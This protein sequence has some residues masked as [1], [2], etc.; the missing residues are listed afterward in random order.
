MEKSTFTLQVQEFAKT[1]T[2]EEKIKLIAM[3]CDTLPERFQ[4][5]I[6]Q[7]L[8]WQ[9]EFTSNEQTYGRPDLDTRLEQALSFL[10]SLPDQS[11]TIEYNRYLDNDWMDEDDEFYSDFYIEDMDFFLD[12]IE[13]VLSL[14]LECEQEKE[15]AKGAQLCAKLATAQTRLIQERNGREMDSYLTPVVDLISGDIL[16]PET[17]LSTAAW[18]GIH[19]CL[20]GEKNEE[21]YANLFDIMNGFETAGFTLKKLEDYLGY[22]LSD[23]FVVNLSRQYAKKSESSAG[24]FLKLAAQYVQDPDARKEILLQAARLHPEILLQYLEAGKDS[25]SQKLETALA[26]LNVMDPL[27]VQ[28]SDTALYCEELIAKTE[29]HKDKLPFVL[30]QIYHS[31]T[32]LFSYLFYLSKSENKES[33]RNRLVQLTKEISTLE[34][35]DPE[36]KEMKDRLLYLDTKIRLNEPAERTNDTLEFLNYSVPAIALTLNMERKQPDFY[37]ARLLPFYLFLLYPGKDTSSLEPVAGYIAAADATRPQILQESSILSNPD[38]SFYYQSLVDWKN[39]VDPEG[40]LAKDEKMQKALEK[41]VEKAAGELF[42]YSGK[43]EAGL[44]AVLLYGLA[45]IQ[46]AKGNTAAK[47]DLQKWLSKRGA[48]KAFKEQLNTLCADEAES[49]KNEIETPG[50]R[51]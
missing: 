28:R 49:I 51:F 48:S 37:L 12:D 1:C 44:A 21:L 38:R 15:Y 30:E 43:E 7:K 26:A 22:P 35:Q 18:A 50:I 23:D 2:E 5:D 46:D 3:L 33:V 8:R 13:D 10:D 39:T 4:E 25:D 40:I 24:E 9:L 42:I 19:C 34:V 31:R 45:E 17:P 20:K 16:K 6:L 41:A 29:E 27:V 32:G 11:V 14:I 47:T 36:L